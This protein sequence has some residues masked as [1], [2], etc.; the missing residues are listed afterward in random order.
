MIL[1]AGG[2]AK[3]TD[4]SVIAAEP[5]LK[6]V[7]GIGEAGVD[8]AAAAGAIGSYMGTLQSAVAAAYDLAAKGDTVLLAPACAS[9]DQ[10][11]SYG[12]R[13]DRFQEMVKKA[14]EEDK[15]K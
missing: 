14:I 11:S 2:L 9:F 8:I 12:E 6:A 5:N 10:F 4:V 1:I 7:V 15:A 13:G 3:G